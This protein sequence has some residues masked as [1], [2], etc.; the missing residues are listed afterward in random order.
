MDCA[1]LGQSPCDNRLS[2]CDA[3]GDP[4][5]I[6]VRNANAPR[7]RSRKCPFRRIVPGGADTTRRNGR[8]RV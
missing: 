5:Q 2:G 7:V 3:A 4:N 6:H 8:F 1:M